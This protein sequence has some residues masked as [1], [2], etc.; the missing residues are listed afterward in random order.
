MRKFN[1]TGDFRIN[2]EMGGDF[3][4]LVRTDKYL[5][6]LQPFAETALQACPY[7]DLL[8]ARQGEYWRKFSII[9]VLNPE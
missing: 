1:K 9:L 7:K 4:E 3:E 2:S 5:E 8:Y 6:I